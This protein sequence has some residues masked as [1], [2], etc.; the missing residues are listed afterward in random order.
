MNCPTEPK[1]GFTAFHSAKQNYKTHR[2][3]GDITTLG[4]AGPV[5][6]L[7]LRTTFATV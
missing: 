7:V 1:R 6:P 3:K 4:A 5:P 2:P